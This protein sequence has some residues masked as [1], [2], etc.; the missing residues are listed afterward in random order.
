MKTLSM[1]LLILILVFS[2]PAQ[3][4]SPADS[5]LLKAK[6]QLNRA[7]RQWNESEL[8]N[9]R[10][11]FERLLNRNDKKFLVHYY[12]AY[13]DYH[14]INFY[15]KDDTA[16]QMKKFLDDGIRHL[17]QSIELNENFSESFA[18]LSSLLGRKISL[19]PLKAIVLGPRS[20]TAI[21][22][23]M[24]LEPQNP[25]VHFISGINAYFT[26]KM[27]GG[28]KNKAR[29]ALKKALQLF[30]QYHSSSP[31]Y[32]DWGYPETYAWLGILAIDADSLEQA[33]TYFHK[34]L[35]IDPDFSWVKNHLLPKLQDEK[36]KAKA[37]D[38][39]RP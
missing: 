25:R 38:Q 9:A 16:D 11:L 22:K 13:A 1:L 6:D 15:Q 30:P 5:L 32:P 20:G 4:L 34:A 24:Q 29:R 37:D 36:A 26:P 14:L 18:L 17:K 8:Q 12:V 3:S 19:N 7:V 31:L 10:A 2:L 35:E 28:G 27:F 33:E 39:Q 21:A 23:A